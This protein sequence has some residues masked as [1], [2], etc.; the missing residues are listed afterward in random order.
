MQVKSR[1][2]PLNIFFLL[3]YLA[4]CE[5]WRGSGEIPRSRLLS[6]WDKEICKVGFHEKLGSQQYFVSNNVWSDW[7]WLRC[8][9][10]RPNILLWSLK[11]RQSFMILN[12]RYSF[13]ILGVCVEVQIVLT[14]AAYDI[15]TRGYGSDMHSLYST[16][17][18]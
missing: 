7:E 9:C 2:S 16:W 3:I 17:N 11:L 1:G 14:K 10:I 8:C 5:F 4:R 6:S 15:W 18:M 13:M 12:S